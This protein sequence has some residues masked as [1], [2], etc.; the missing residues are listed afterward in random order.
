MK[1]YDFSVAREKIS[2]IIEKPN[3]SENIKEET[4]LSYA[5]YPQVK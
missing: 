4:V 3:N 1:P 2:S 5:L